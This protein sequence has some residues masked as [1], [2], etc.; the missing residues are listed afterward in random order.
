MIGV[1]RTSLEGAPLTY[2]RS[3]ATAES[4]ETRNTAGEQP[5]PKRA[6]PVRYRMSGPFAGPLQPGLFHGEDDAVGAR[7]ILQQPVGD[8]APPRPM[9]RCHRHISRTCRFSTH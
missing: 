5:N 8:S 1:I 3:S 4:E 7:R 6:D 9:C 2:T